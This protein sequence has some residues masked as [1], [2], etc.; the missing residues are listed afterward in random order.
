MKNAHCL[1]GGYGS[2][3]NGKHEVAGQSAQLCDHA[4]LDIGGEVPQIEHPPPSAVDAEAI[5]MELH[6][7]RA[8][9][10]LEAV[11][12]RLSTSEIKIINLFPSPEEIMKD[13]QPGSAVQLF[14]AGRKLGQVGAD[15]SPHSGKVAAGLINIPLGCA[16][17][18]VSFLQNA[19]I[20]PG[21][22]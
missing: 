10:I 16:D 6:A 1:V 5:P 22:L 8:E 4:V 19:V 18:D 20:A 9:P 21:N 7:V 12:Q 13:P 3:I 15:V 2:N 11:P 14:S 17:C